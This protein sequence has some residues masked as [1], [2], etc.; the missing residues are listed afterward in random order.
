MRKPQATQDARDA[1]A[2]AIGKTVKR[3][4]LES[5]AVLEARLEGRGVTLAQLRMLGALNDAAANDAVPSAAE[6]ARIC[7]VTPQSMQALVT[8]AERE[9][10]IVRRP[11]PE[12]R[13]VLTARLTAQGKRVYERGKGQMSA[14]GRVLWSGTSLE[15]MDRVN[16]V[17]SLAVDRLQ[18]M[19]EGLRDK[20]HRGRTG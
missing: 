12:N 4:V 15:D 8:R 13:R 1:E 19:H 14:I 2:D 16:R 7:G 5:R 9:G 11:S 10:W 6:L 3:L 20:K 17:L 18:S